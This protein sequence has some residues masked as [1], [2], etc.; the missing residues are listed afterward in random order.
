MKNSLRIKKVSDNY[1]DYTYHER[2]LDALASMFAVQKPSTA[3][4]FYEQKFYLSYNA[5][6]P[7]KTQKIVNDIATTLNQCIRNEVNIDGLVSLYLQHNA[8]FND[9]IKKYT[10]QLT[11]N[12]DKLFTTGYSDNDLKSLENLI[13]SNTPAELNLS[14]I[15]SIHNEV[16]KRNETITQKRTELTTAINNLKASTSHV[17]LYKTLLQ[18]IADIKDICNPGE[19]LQLAATLIRPLQDVEKLVHYFRQNKQ[20][21]SFDILDNPKISK[22]T[23]HAEMN[24]AQHFPHLEGVYIGV[25]RLCCGGCDYMLENFY[26][27]KHRG[28]HG[29]L[30]PKWGILLK[31]FVNIT[32]QLEDKAKFLDQNSLNDQLA[33]QHRKLSDDEDWNA[34]INI[35]KSIDFEFMHFKKEFGMY[36]QPIGQESFFSDDAKD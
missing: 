22:I 23:L 9:N 1:E 32:R 25:S 28:T 7:P 15:E 34:E 14:D 20:E 33:A 31:Q 21:I 5:G 4:L 36:E 17:D 18:L 16:R 27:Y 6:A 2:Y 12:L 3:V 26:H 8:D 35:F 29:T 19:F 11:S 24:I 30:D 10:K 13:T